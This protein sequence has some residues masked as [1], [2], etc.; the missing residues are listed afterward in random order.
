MF[1]KPICKR[2]IFV[3]VDNP[4]KT[5]SGQ[6]YYS[7]FGYISAIDREFN[8]KI[9]VYFIGKGHIWFNRNQINVLRGRELTC[10][11][12]THDSI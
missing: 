11:T 10:Q 3:N 2:K 7:G 5:K 9:C 6:S 8:N 4:E 12:E 1:R